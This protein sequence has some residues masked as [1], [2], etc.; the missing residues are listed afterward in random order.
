MRVDVLVYSRFV[1]KIYSIFAKRNIK[2]IRHIVINVLKKVLKR[3]LKI[4]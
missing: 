1:K 3:N 4:K 2:H